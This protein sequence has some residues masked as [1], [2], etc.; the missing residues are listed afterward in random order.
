[1][2]IQPGRARRQ[3]LT[4]ELRGTLHANIAASHIYNRWPTNTELENKGIRKSSTSRGISYHSM[5]GIARLYMLE[6]WR[7]RRKLR[8]VPKQRSV[9][10]R[11]L[12]LMMQLT[13]VESTA[14]SSGTAIWLPATNVGLLLHHGGRYRRRWTSHSHTSARVDNGYRIASA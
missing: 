5:G 7:R 9:E 10:A 2:Q 6:C 3:S 14:R 11:H 1:M 4:S 12:D 8:S 13:V